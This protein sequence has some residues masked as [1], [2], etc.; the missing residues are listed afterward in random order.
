MF[1]INLEDGREEPYKASFYK[2]F[3]SFI[4]SFIRS[5]NISCQKNK[6]LKTKP[7]ILKSNV[8]QRFKIAEFLAENLIEQKPEQR[9][10]LLGIT[11]IKRGGG[12][13]HIPLVNN[14]PKF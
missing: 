5:F 8:V 14:V 3:Y 9:I 11:H 4:H 2:L 12:A 7:Q 10:F 6:G 1:T 13:K